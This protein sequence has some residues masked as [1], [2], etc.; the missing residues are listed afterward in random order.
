MPDERKSAR[1]SL[2][3]AMPIPEG[4][5]AFSRK[6][7]GLLDGQ[8]KDEATVHQALAGMDEMLD[9]IAAGLYS[10]ASMLVG[11]GED[12]IRLVETAVSRADITGC[13]GDARMARQSSRRELCSAAIETLVKRNPQSLAAPK[14]I[15]PATTCIEDDDL[16]AA[17][18][19]TEELESML[20]GP[21]RE[22]VRR[23]LEGLSTET[24]VIFVIRAVAGFSSD[25]TASLLADHGGPCA[26]GWTADGVRVA[27]RQG[28][29]SLASQLIQATN[30]R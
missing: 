1:E 21:N 16:S 20:A 30:A 8:P 23:W 28:L 12:G 6:V 15:E 25:E 4:G 26:R 2:I 27:F 18:I 5:E 19:S 24:R 14:D 9:K 10:L 11:E 3:P 17:G 13:G 29:C 7:H 22:S